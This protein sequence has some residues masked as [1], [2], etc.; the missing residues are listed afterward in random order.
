MAQDKTSQLPHTNQN[1][2]EGNWLY[3]RTFFFLILHAHYMISKL[4]DHTVD[5]Q[6]TE[7]S[8]FITLTNMEVSKRNMG[9]QGDL[10]QKEHA[11][12]MS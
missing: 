2:L 9:N 7:Q 12:G 4:V 11:P 3:T 6:T 10:V 8:N 5:E 1:L